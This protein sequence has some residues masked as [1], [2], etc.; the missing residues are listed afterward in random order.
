MGCQKCEIKTVK[1]TS[2]YTSFYTITMKRKT[3]E[4]LNQIRD[5]L[6]VSLMAIQDLPE[7]TEMHNWHKQRLE[8][9]YEQ[10]KG[11]NENDRTRPN[12]TEIAG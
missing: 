2:L 7:N 6:T 3:M 12:D 9:W 5:D 1:L 4:F 8:F 10:L 11:G